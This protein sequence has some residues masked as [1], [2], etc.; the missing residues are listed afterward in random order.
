MTVTAP[1]MGV[2]PGDGAPVFSVD[3]AVKVLLAGRASIA[4]VAKSAVVDMGVAGPAGRVDAGDTITYTYTVRNGGEVPVEGVTVT[5]PVF[6]GFA[7]GDAGEV[8][9]PAATRTCTRTVVLTQGQ[10]DEGSVASAGAS[11]TAKPS[12]PAAGRMAVSGDVA[13]GEATTGRGGRRWGW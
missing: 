5:D 13:A 8:L 10:V 9:A 2:P 12:G 3:R 6:G 1:A 11:V 7:C 4:A